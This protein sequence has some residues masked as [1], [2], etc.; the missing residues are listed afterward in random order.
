MEVHAGHRL[1]HAVQLFQE[2]TA[3]QHLAGG[4]GLWR[5]EHPAERA[6]VRRSQGDDRLDLVRSSEIPQV[7][8][9]DEPA[10]AVRHD[11]DVPVLRIVNLDLLG[12]FAGV[13]GYRI[14]SAHVRKIYRIAVEPVELETQFH[15]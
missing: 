5:Q 3:W 6:M 9:C 12:K 15:R 11:H 14:Q 13:V 10:H 7:I 4:N 8:A 2:A 1:G